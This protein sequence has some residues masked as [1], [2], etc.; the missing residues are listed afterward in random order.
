MREGGGWGLKECLVGGG[1]ERVSGVWL[2]SVSGVGVSIEYLG[3][4]RGGG[5]GGED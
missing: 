2:N 4:Q 5:G 1:L 3:R